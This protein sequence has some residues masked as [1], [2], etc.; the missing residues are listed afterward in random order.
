MKTLR[1]LLGQEGTSTL[2]MIVVL[3]TL[4]FIMFAAVELSRAWM[5]AHVATSAVREGARL[6]AVTPVAQNPIGI[7]TTRINEVLSSANL[8]PLTAPTVTCTPAPC[9]QDS[10]VDASVTVRFQT[11]FP[12]LL[13]M[14]QTKDISETASIRYE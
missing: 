6:A 14:L 13:P 12:V 8:T 5:T 1:R 4:L 3:P 7:A 9:A 11:L 10:R 2:E